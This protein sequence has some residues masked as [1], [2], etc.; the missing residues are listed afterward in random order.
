M[1]R[2][3]TFILPVAVWVAVLC[4]IPSAARA[5]CGSIPFYAPILGG[6][7]FILDDTNSRDVDFDPLEVTIFEPHQRAII[8]WDGREQILLLSTDQRATEQTAVLEVIPLPSKPTVQL[9]QF[10]TFELAQRMVVEKHLWACA[11]AGARSELLKL[12]KPA[13]RIEFHEKLGAHDLTVAEVLDGDRFVD[14]VQGYLSDRYQTQAAPIRPEFVR[15]IQSYLDEGFRWFAFD[16]ISLDGTTRS[17][18]PIQ[19]RFQSDYVFYP[20]RIST[21]EQGKTKV[22]LLVFTAEGVNQFEGLPAKQI[23]TFPTMDV[24]PKELGGLNAD[25]SGFFGEA[26]SLR[27]DRWQIKGKL[28]KF[29]AD[30]RVR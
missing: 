30:V 20:M 17:R 27:M 12:P 16:V 11:H 21:L 29:V 2:I 22:D 9:G 7:D 10:E 26:A 6:V 18:E 15:I 5:D 3:E 14:F 13:G 4:S 24:S 19:Y 8:L 1:K 28:S 23:K 25:W